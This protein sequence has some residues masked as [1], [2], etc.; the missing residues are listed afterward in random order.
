VHANLTLSQREKLNWHVRT[1]N[2]LKRDYLGLTLLA[3]IWRDVKREI[4]ETGRLS[5]ATERLLVATIGFSD[6]PLVMACTSFGNQTVEEN[7]SHKSANGESHTA[8]SD[9]RVE[10]EKKELIAVIDQELK[11]LDVLK[12]F[13]R[14]RRPL[15]VESEILSRSL[16]PAGPSDK[17]LRYDAH[18]ERQLYRAMHQLERLQRL[19]K[20][21]AV[22]PP[23]T[24]R[25]N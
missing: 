9:E 11:R 4:S 17:I 3:S 12:D 8:I 25:F 2:D 13:A 20:G 5:E 15:R 1:Q 14:A 24:V 6:H 23:L 16:P 19:R 7:E 10:L 22:P 18:I 21:E